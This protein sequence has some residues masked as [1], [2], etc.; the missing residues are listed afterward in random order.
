MAFNFNKKTNKPNG[1]RK[2]KVMPKNR[3]HFDIMDMWN[4]GVA[5]IW[6]WFFCSVSSSSHFIITFYTMYFTAV[7]QIGVIAHD[8]GEWYH[9]Q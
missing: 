9:G 5:V 2:K 3:N 7:S 8:K 6:Y 4:G 1:E